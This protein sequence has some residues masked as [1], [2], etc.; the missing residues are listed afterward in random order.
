M[1]LSCFANSLVLQHRLQHPLELQATFP[2][3]SLPAVCNLAAPHEVYV[4]KIT[5]AEEQRGKSGNSV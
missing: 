2:H 4:I 5:F 1:I 3:L